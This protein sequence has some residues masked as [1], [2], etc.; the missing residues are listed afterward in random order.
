MNA[1][2]QGTVYGLFFA[3]AI[4]WVLYIGKGVFVPIVFSVLV[5]Y[6]IVGLARM[7]VRLP[8]FGRFLPPQIV[9]LLSALVIALMLAGIASLVAGSIGNVS[10]LAPKYAASLLN[11]IQ[12]AA[13]RLGVELA[14]TW[15]AL[16][17]DVLAQIN[18]QRLIG[19]TML[20]VS[21][22][23]ST[24][25]VV[26]LY[27][28]FLLI[29]QRTFST[30][31]ARISSDPQ[32]VL[33]IQKI[34][35]QINARIGAYLALKTVV[36]VIQG[37]VSWAVLEF[38]GVEFAAFWAVLIGMLNYVP[39]LG[40]VLGVVFPV[41]FATMQFADFG[42]ALVVLVSLSATQFVIGFFLDPYLMGNSLNLSPF[43][44][45]VS[46]AVWSALW[47]IP[48]AFLAVPITACMVLVFAEF[49][50]TRP[51]AILLSQNGQI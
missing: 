10:A 34:I 9:H 51:I 49:S 37:L 30:K 42:I 16:R 47:G 24:L 1:R 32:N 13:E 48:G 33:Q 3:L 14:P 29:E 43:V 6:V 36:S 22:I 46:L 50:G 27:V 19:S 35:A 26:L 21:A 12:G 8:L 20:S 38:I 18:T 17:Q 11:A 39:Y 5:V 15:T 40:S 45:L 41:A 44:I 2:F 25:V 28:V 23:V 7:L 31:I 4:G